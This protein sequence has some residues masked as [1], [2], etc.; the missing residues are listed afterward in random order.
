MDRWIDGSWMGRWID[1]HV[2]GREQDVGG[3]STE[4]EV[5]TVACVLPKGVHDSTI[6]VLFYLYRDCNDGY[7]ENLNELCKVIKCISII[8]DII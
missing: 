5:G 2:S 6:S 7:Y 1:G 3:G 8:V 4:L